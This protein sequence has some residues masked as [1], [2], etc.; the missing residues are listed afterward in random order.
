MRSGVNLSNEDI[1][2]GKSVV[3]LGH[4]VAEKLFPWTDPL[5]RV[6]KIDGRKFRV[7][8]I[9]EEK[10]SSFGGRYDNYML[11]PITK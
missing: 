3:V 11:I 1:K 5:Q 10:K 7:I 2:I 8:G 4:A 9:L 6:I